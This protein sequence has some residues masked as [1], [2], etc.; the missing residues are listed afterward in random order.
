MAY[1]AMKPCNFAG[2]KYFKG[3]S[4][5]EEVVLPERVTALVKHGVIAEVSE[6][7]QEDEIL[8]HIPVHAQEGDLDCA[9]TSEELVQVFD[10]LQADVSEAEA[11]IDGITKNDALILLDVSESRKTVNKLVKQRAAKLFS[12]D[13]AEE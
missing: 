1:I 13:S 9:L 6:E 7:V 2:Q 11:L 4:V 8:I 10:V 3:D 5:P 12:V